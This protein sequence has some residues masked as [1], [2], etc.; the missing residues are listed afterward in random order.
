MSALL[1]AIAEKQRRDHDLAVDSNRVVA[2][3]GATEALLLTL[4][5]TAKA[6]EKVVIPT[7]VWPQYRLQVTK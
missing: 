6:G 5:T 3:A 7:P 2:T 4:L 1:E